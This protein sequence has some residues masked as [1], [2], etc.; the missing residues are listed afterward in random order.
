MGFFTSIIDTVCSHFNVEDM[1]DKIWFSTADDKP[2][3][4]HLPIGFLYDIAKSSTSKD[5]LLPW[6][7][8]VRF[9]KFPSNSILELADK[10]AAEENFFHS[11]KQAV[12]I[13]RGSAKSV[14]SIT[15]SEQSE[16]WDAVTKCS[17]V[18]S[19]HF[20]SFFVSLFY[21]FLILVS[22]FKTKCIQV[23][24]LNSKMHKKK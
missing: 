1:K 9:S 15:R 14:M 18:P 2:I 8:I 11:L 17:F 16:M 7:L 23:I 20:I 12:Y 19:S 5:D 6:T 3:Q 4:W 13:Q 24:I 10:N 22:H 21:L